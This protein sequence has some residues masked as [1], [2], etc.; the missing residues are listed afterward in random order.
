LTAATSS[1]SLSAGIAW[2]SFLLS[3]L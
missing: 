2:T 3:R 1:S